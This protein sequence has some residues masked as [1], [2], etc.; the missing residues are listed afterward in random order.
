MTDAH[1]IPAATQWH[2]GML[3]APQH[4]QQLSIR[5][6]ELLHYQLTLA[7]PFHWGVRRLKI[8]PSLLVDGKLRVLD[9]EAV[10]PDGLI[11]SYLPGDDHLMKI[12]LA[13]YAE[14]MKQRP[15]SVH[16]AVPIKKIGSTVTRGDLA[17]F[18]SVEGNPVVDENTG[19]SEISIPRLRPR[20]SLLVT[21]TPPQKYTTI[22]LVKVAFENE[23]FSLT[24]YIAP[25][26]SVP[27]TSSVGEIC[28][29][30][31]H[32]LREKAIF[33]SE[34][35]NAPDSPFRGSMV[36]ETKMLIQSMVSAL[37]PFEAILNTGVSHPYPLYLSLC[38]LV[39]HLAALGLGQVPPVL[40]PYNHND[41]RSTFVRSREFIYRMI[42][43][44]VLESHT[45]VSFHFENGMFGLKLKKEWLTPS[46]AVGV[47]GRPGATE[48]DIMA[49]LQEALIGS[50]SLTETMK[51]KRILGASRTKIERD[52]ELVPARGVVLFS[53]KADPEFILPEE[54]LQICNTSDPSGRLSPAEI[55]LYV[56]NKP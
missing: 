36:L 22:P 46:M 51:E 49:W 43:E 29:A 12:D 23:T 1:H 19:E 8:D 18:E 34:K 54:T 11:V 42:D 4:F 48:N 17:R 35:V 27:V 26:L 31:A 20:V 33:L 37:P 24:D 39:G 6:E 16:L 50:E 13:P 47:R 52:E 28:S 3:L 15:V 25:M 45:A 9:L 7:A 38:S 30:V 10:M 32:R 5:L 56:K 40:E 2:E 41:L 53:L 21:D 14:E 44:G 55:T